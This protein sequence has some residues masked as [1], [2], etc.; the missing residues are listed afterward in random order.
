MFLLKDSNSGTYFK[1]SSSLIT[2]QGLG[3]KS[4]ESNLTL[5]EKRSDA[6]L[7][8]KEEAQK[9]IDSFYKTGHGV[10]FQLVSPKFVIYNEVRK[11]YLREFKTVRLD[12]INISFCHEITSAHT[13]KNEDILDGILKIAQLS[14]NESLIAVVTEN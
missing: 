11:T 2:D 10:D 8:T 7:F 14:T 3:A 1:Q 4:V 5:T 9:T 12:Q 6:R 13:F